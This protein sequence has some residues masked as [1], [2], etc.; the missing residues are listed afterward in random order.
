ME[1][2]FSIMRERKKREFDPIVANIRDTL[3]SAETS[4]DGI[5]LERLKQMDRMLATFDKLSSRLL[6]GE[7]Q[8]RAVLSF[9]TERT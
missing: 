2:L 6:A 1:M 4:P 5:A 8:A 9:L 7:S 3:E